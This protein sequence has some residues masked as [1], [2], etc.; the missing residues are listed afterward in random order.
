M[1]VISSGVVDDGQ[2]VVKTIDVR[3]LD[4]TQLNVM[5]GVVQSYHIEL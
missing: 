1:V 4:Q 3:Q 2:T 5:K